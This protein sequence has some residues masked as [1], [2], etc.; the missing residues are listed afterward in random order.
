MI[1]VNYITDPGHGWLKVPLKKMAKLGIVDKISTF[2]Y[3]R[4]AYA[5]LEED[6]DAATFIEACEAQG[7]KYGILSNSSGN[8]YSR[9]R[10]YPRYTVTAANAALN[11]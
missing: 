9:V 11:K 10:N 2:S 5:Y 8:R 4:G 6:C 3:I 7:I 1:N